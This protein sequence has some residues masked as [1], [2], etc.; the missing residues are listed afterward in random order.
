MS[1]SFCVAS[2]RLCSIRWAGVLTVDTYKT[3]DEMEKH[4]K[5]ECNEIPQVHVG[6]RTAHSAA[7]VHCLVRKAIHLQH[8]DLKVAT[9]AQGRIVERLT[10]I[11]LPVTD[12]FVHPYR[13]TLPLSMQIVNHNLSY[14]EITIE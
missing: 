2:C 10:G 1:Y 6:G 12:V 9:V 14:D 13:L 5:E 4:I 8:S 7:S 3:K 11:R